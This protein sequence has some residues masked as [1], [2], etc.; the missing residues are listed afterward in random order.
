M[1]SKIIMD[2]HYLDGEVV[3]HELTKDT[4]NG[5]TEWKHWGDETTADGRPKPTV[6]PEWMLVRRVRQHLSRMLAGSVKARFNR[7]VLWFNR[8]QVVSSPSKSRPIFEANGTPYRVSRC[9]TCSE[10][11]GEEKDTW[12][13]VVN[14]APYSFACRHKQRYEGQSEFG[15]YTL[16]TL[17]N[18][19]KTATQI[20]LIGR[21]FDETDAHGN[22]LTWPIKGRSGDWKCVMCGRAKTFEHAVVGVKIELGREF[23]RRIMSKDGSQRMYTTKYKRRR[24]FFMEVRLGGVD[25]I[26][27]MKGSSD[28]DFGQGHSG[29]V[30]FD[31]FTST[32]KPGELTE[33]DTISVIPD[34]SALPIVQYTPAPGVVWCEELKLKHLSK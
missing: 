26:K 12:W 1:I 9:K 24:T 18:A 5:R 27:A 11:I 17:D 33:L 3:R 19:D 22:R 21:W 10:S 34:V 4:F 29:L 2:E 13:N 15:A 8:F 20:A 14:A 7:D 25:T 28:S 6:A 32:S 30:E 16:H 23:P 31:Q